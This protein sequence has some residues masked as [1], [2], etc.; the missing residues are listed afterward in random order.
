M[1][2]FSKSRSSK[3]GLKRGISNRQ[4]CIASAID[5]YDNL[6]II[7]T[8]PITSKEIKQV[9]QNKIEDT[10]NS[11][12]ITNCKS[13][14]ESFVKDN[15]IKLERVK[16]ETHVNLNG[17]NL[18]NI[19]CIHSDLSTFLSHFRGVSTKHLQHYLDWFNFQKLINYITH[20]LKQPLVM[21]KKTLKH[22][23]HINSNNTYQNLSGIDFF[24]VYSDYNFNSL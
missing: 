10:D 18:A 3:G 1:P 16:S 5:E 4:V 6:K 19:N 8:N 9:F 13:S 12:L 2:R 23:C 21:M 17:Y 20:V 22:C 24:S 15:R 11:L 7:G 14:Y